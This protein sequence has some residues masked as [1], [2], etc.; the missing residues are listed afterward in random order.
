MTSSLPSSVTSHPRDSY[1]RT[2]SSCG[3]LCGGPAHPAFGSYD[4]DTTSIRP[5]GANRVTRALAY[6]REATAPDGNE[7]AAVPH[8]VHRGSAAGREPQSF[9]AERYAALRPDPGVQGRRRRVG[10]LVDM[11]FDDDLATRD[12]ASSDAPTPNH[13]RRESSSSGLGSGSG[14]IE[15]RSPSTM[16]MLPLVWTLL[17]TGAPSFGDHRVRRRRRP[18]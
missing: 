17:T 16:A 18:R 6:H 3:T 8:R 9:L 10:V 2:S 1:R 14:R 12:S 4:T 13:P 15:K 11:L 5:P 7:G